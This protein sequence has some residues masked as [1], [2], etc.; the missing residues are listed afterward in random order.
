MAETIELSQRTIER[1]EHGA[2]VS[3]RVLVAIAKALGV[4]DDDLATALQDVPRTKR[5][6]PLEIIRVFV[7]SPEIWGRSVSPSEG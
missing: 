6:G 5:D 1:A 3:S 7:A 4:A 2:A